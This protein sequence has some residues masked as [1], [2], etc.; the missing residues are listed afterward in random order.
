M[1]IQ[2]MESL[3]RMMREYGISRVEVNEKGCVVM[4]RQTPGTVCWEAPDRIAAAEE[5]RETPDTGETIPVEEGK[6][7]KSPMVGVF[8]A[9]SSPDADPFVKSGDRI[10]KGDVLCIIE[11][12]KLM[13][14]INAETDGEILEVLAENGQLVENGAPLFRIR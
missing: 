1:K 6:I 5:G 13:N 3:A 8:Y 12:M 4:E 2:D 11:A 14:E 7:V 9:A 10:H